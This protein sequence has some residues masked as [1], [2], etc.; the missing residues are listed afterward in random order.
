MK[1]NLL[2]K[3]IKQNWNKHMPFAFFK[4]EEEHTQRSANTK[5]TKDDVF[6]ITLLAFVAAF[7]MIWVKVMVL[8]R[9]STFPDNSYFLTWHNLTP[10]LTIIGSCIYIYCLY[11]KRIDY[12]LAYLPAVIAIVYCLLEISLIEGLL[13]PSVLK[14][15]F[16]PFANNLPEWLTGRPIP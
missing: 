12:W 5:L 16:G 14:N 11:A 15:F 6:A 8:M 9:F 3:K 2:K 7:L 10:W 13:H 4:K 1:K